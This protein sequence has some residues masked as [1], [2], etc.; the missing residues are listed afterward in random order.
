MAG[1]LNRLLRKR[2]Q[3]ELYPKSTDNVHEGVYNR[4][5]STFLGKREGKDEYCAMMGTIEYFIVT[6]IDDYKTHVVRVTKATDDST[7]TVF[8]SSYSADS[9]IFDRHVSQ[10]TVSD[11][12]NAYS[13]SDYTRQ[14]SEPQDVFGLRRVG[15]LDD[16]VQMMKSGRS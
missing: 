1:L 9:K 6:E 15:T 7:G 13:L 14:Y 4:W 8:S 3:P 16:F 10:V 11:V 2:E 5:K 12:M